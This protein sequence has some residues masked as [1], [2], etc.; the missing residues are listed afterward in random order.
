MDAVYGYAA[1]NVEAQETDP[2]SLLHWMRNM[3]WLRQ[4]FTVFGR[5]T[6]EFLSPKNA[7]VLAYV[8]RYEDDMI[9]CVANLA[10][11]VQPAELDLAHFAG[12]TPVEMLGYTEFPA[13]GTLPYFLTL[14]PYA[15][16]WFELQRPR[17]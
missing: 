7:K 5:G 8:R 9:L 17:R 13:I 6:L 1:V 3:I 10:G 16:Y 15:F 4:M 12:L 11:S 2:A 14:G